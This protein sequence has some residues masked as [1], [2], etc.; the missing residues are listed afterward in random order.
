MN[1]ID[2]A[3]DSV[4]GFTVSNDIW[5][6]VRR[7]AAFTRVYWSLR[8]GVKDTIRS[9]LSLAQTTKNSRKPFHPRVRGTKF[10]LGT[11]WPE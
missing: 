1:N 10:L 4:D 8:R 9:A 2:Q 11:T 6:R 3:Y 5:W 7:E